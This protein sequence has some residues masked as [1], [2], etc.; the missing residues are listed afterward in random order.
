[1]SEQAKHTP[2]PWLLRSSTVYALDA[3]GTTN[4]FWAQPQVGWV[5]NG[6][7]YTSEDELTANARLIAAAPDLL[8]AANRALNYIQA[9][10][11][12][13]GITLDSGDMLR[14]AIAK[15]LGQ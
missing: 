8:A 5:E 9:T 11:G 4:R 14:A 3:T 1:M 15:A 13:L 6:V 7:A 12:E 10:E 2:G